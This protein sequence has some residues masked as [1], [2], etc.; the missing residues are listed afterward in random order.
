MP[1]YRISGTLTGIIE[2]ENVAE[3]QAYLTDDDMTQYLDDSIAKRI[4]HVEWKLEADGHAWSVTAFA[5]RRLSED[6]QR[7]LSEWVSGQNS[8]GLGEGFE[9]QDFAWD[10]DEE[11]ECY[12]CRGTGSI[13][14]DDDGYE[15]SEDCDMCGGSG[16][17]ESDGRMISFDWKTNPHIV[18]R[19]K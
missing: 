13:I 11:T 9:Q 7:V 10:E 18:E 5:T 14:C 3:A 6:E 16:T 17:H 15:L 12:E 2:P 4:E 19:V 1:I 8:D